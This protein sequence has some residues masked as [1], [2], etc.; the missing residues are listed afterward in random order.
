V[1]GFGGNAAGSA[2]HDIQPSHSR[3]QCPAMTSVNT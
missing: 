1:L 3:L 2:M